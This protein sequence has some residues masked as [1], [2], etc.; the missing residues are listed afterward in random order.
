MVKVASLSSNFLD[1]AFIAINNAYNG[2]WS[3]PIKNYQLMGE[4][5]AIT[6]KR[7]RAK[8]ASEASGPQKTKKWRLGGNLKFSGCGPIRV[9]TIQ[10]IISELYL[11]IL[12]EDVSCSLCCFAIGGPGDY[13]ERATQ[14]PVIYIFNCKLT[15]R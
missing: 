10:F 4:A 7:S 6:R 13:I 12:R 11:Y 5:I 1:L 9:P 3:M 8:F 2:Q 15:I 14:R